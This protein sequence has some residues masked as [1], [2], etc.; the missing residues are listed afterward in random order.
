[1][2]RACTCNSC[3]QIPHIRFLSLEV[4]EFLEEQLK[5]YVSTQTLTFFH[6]LP[7]SQFC[8]SGDLPCTVIVAQILISLSRSRINNNFLLLSSL[9]R[10]SQ[11]EEEEECRDLW[12]C[13][14]DGPLVIFITFGLWKCQESGW[15]NANLLIG[16]IVP[17]NN[18]TNRISKWHGKK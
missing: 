6:Y 16:P 7:V 1:M 3:N 17:T 12:S 8:N 15:C 9:N 14:E 18:L 2:W 13:C 5:W 11:E 4:E 10:L